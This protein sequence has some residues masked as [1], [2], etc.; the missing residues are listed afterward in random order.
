[1]KKILF[2]FLI[3]ILTL[4]GLGVYV[5]KKVVSKAP[6]LS[7]DFKL[8]A[9]ELKGLPQETTT[10]NQNIEIVIKEDDLNK[11]AKEVL[12]DPL[13]SLNFSI[14]QDAIYAGGLLEKSFLRANFTIVFEPVAENG[15]LKLEVKKRE[16]K[17]STTLGV[18]L[19]PFL[20]MID[21][22]VDKNIN[23]KLVVEKFLLEE[24]SLMVTG[25]A[26]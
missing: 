14:R 24:G 8:P 12:A 15:K 20:K 22:L 13:K 3:F 10:K 2:V 19:D 6:Q 18:L 9:I 11:E 21:E 1:M 16:I 23:D 25:R 7:M 17:G 5:F 26:K 4:T